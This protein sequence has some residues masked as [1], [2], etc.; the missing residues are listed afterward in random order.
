MSELLCDLV[1]RAE[2]GDFA[3][4]EVLGDA[5]HESEFH[6]LRVLALLSEAEWIRTKIDVEAEDRLELARSL[7]LAKV[8]SKALKVQGTTVSAREVW[9]LAVHASVLSSEWQTTWSGCES[10]V[11]RV[12]ML[13]VDAL[14]ETPKTTCRVIEETIDTWDE[15]WLR[16]QRV[17]MGESGVW[18]DS[19]APLRLTLYCSHGLVARK[20]SFA[21]APR[22]EQELP[23][24]R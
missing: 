12:G 22:A 21:I 10:S 6:A 14:D 18:E 2:N 16:L 7:C 24:F 3:A 19:G 9:L 20:V 4:G 15:R 11:F 13:V 8:R 23:E 5:I 17:N 1:V